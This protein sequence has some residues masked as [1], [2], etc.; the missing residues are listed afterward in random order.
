MDHTR[1]LKSIANALATSKIN[2]TSLENLKLWL[3]DVR[4]NSF[5]DDIIK[6]IEQADWAELDD[7]F[8]TSIPFGTGGRRG[9]C[10]VGPNRIN[11]RTIG[12][13]AQ[14][15][16]NYLK[17][18][19]DR[20]IKK[21]VVIAYD[22]RVKSR[23][24]AHLTAEILSGNGIKTYLFDGPRATPELSFAVRHLKTQAGVVIS[25]SHN[26]PSDN[27][28]KVYN[29]HGGQIVPP[30][31]AII[32]A[33]VRKVIDI[34]ALS[35]SEKRAQTSIEYIGQSVDEVYWQLLVGL[36]LRPTH[37]A[38]IVFSPL[39]G[40][41]STNILPVLEKVGYPVSKVKEQMPFDGTFPTCPKNV[42]N[43]EVVET[44]DRAIDQ[45]KLEKA[46][47]AIVSDPD[48]DRIGVAAPDASGNWQIFSGN[49]VGALA[50]EYIGQ[51]L[52]E[53][54]K[55]PKKGVVIE[56]VVTSRLIGDIGR[57]WGFG[58]IDELLVGFKFIADCVEHLAEGEKLFFAVEESLG[59]LR[60][61][62]VRDKDAAQGALTIAECASHAK[63]QRQKLPNLLNEL[64]IRHG[65]YQEMLHTIS[66][67]GA[68]GV[69]TM[70]AI[71]QRLRND[72]PTQV[73]GLVVTNV[74]DRL[75]GPPPNDNLLIFHL[76][77][78]GRNRLAVR[79]SGT[80]PKLKCYISAWGTVK[81]PADLVNVKQSVD[82]QAYQIVAFIKSL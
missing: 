37:S 70:M 25:A 82:R 54:D 13:S 60:T 80:E 43:P 6:L 4:Y 40:T 39:H 72:P 48:A 59:Y 47:L 62:E 27:G 28:F 11:E 79:P 8:R 9:P 49:Q 78:A 26:P 3:T 73:A 12:E 46:D 7:A 57:Y 18:L 42:P 35:S 56:T 30:E 5:R 69:E 2:E 22:T 20:A 41:G 67:P 31:D 44:L 76:D 58:V 75:V 32:M 17:K 45:A 33:E 52:K 77:Q 36:S 65:Y 55:L 34:I 14:G 29:S 15:L 38:K 51:S 19:G 53:L 24:F 63:D 68:K 64:Y 16:A 23:E 10:G 21:G 50:I 81:S 61:T 66:Y 74:I 71:M 1:V